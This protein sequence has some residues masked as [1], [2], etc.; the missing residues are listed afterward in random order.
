MTPAPSQ[1][2]RPGLETIRRFA[3]PPAGV[4]VDLSD[5][6]NVWGA[7]PAAVASIAANAG[8]AWRS[9]SL[10]G[11]PLRLALAY[12]LSPAHIVTGNGSTEVLRVI[13]D[14]PGLVIPDE[15][16]ADDAGET[17]VAEAAVRSNLLVVR[18][19]SKSYGLASLRVGYGVAHPDIVLALERVR[20]PYA[21]SRVAECAAVAAVEAARSVEAVP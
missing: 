12:G 16:Y 20:G 18:T 13:D 19:F 14:A 5:S 4:F 9:P 2:P 7:A 21:V 11:E 10:Y 3:P 8:E 15:E 6:A 17:L 1:S